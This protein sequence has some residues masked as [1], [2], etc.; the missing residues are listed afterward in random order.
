MSYTP[1][2]YATAVELKTAL[3]Y[4]ADALL[5]D[6]SEEGATTEMERVILET[7]AMIDS[8]ISGRVS[9]PVA[10]GNAVLKRICLTVSKYDLWSR[11]SAADVPEALKSDYEG[12]LKVLEK[13]ARGEIAFAADAPASI[14]AGE[15]ESS[16][17]VMNAGLD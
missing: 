2:A 9:V 14:V 3:G 1:V 16:S 4:Q 17:R 15:F 13:I 12:Q 10:N 11:Q 5:S 8:M 6:F 7:S